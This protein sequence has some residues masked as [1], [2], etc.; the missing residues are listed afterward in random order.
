MNP[1]LIFSLMGL[2]AFLILSSC[3]D[4]APMAKADAPDP[5]Q[6]QLFNLIPASKTGLTFNNLLEENLKVNYLR[7]DG[8]YMGGGVGVGDLNNDGLDDLYF[9]GN[10]AKDQLYI[11]KGNLKFEN[12]TQTS[13]IK[14]GDTWSTGVSFVDVN[15]DGWLDIYVC[16]FLYEEAARRKN[17]LYINNG[18]LTFT[19][20]AEKY[21]IADTGY[22]IQ[23]NFFDYDKD[24]FLD[25]YIANQ[26]P[27][28]V[29]LK[30][31][32]TG[33]KDF[34]YTDR[35]Y[36]NN[37]NGSFTDVTEKAGITNYSFS[38]SCTVSDLNQDGWPDI[39]VA[40]DYEEPDF[41]YENNGDGTYRNVA[42]DAIRHMSN[43]SMGA[44]IA[45]INND[46]WFDIYTAD[47]VAADNFRLKTNMS[48]MNPEKF[49]ALAD[50]GYH[51]QFMFNALQLNNGNGTF[52]E[53]A[54]MS[55]VSNTDWSWSALLA[56]LD[57]DGYKDLHVT[58]GQLRD[59]RNNDYLI[60]RKAYVAKKKAEGVKAFN[61]LDILAL[62]PSV[63]IKNYTYR[64]NGDLTF[65]NMIEKWGL[66]QATFSQGSAYADLDNDGDLDLVLN[67]TN[68]MAGLYEN[69]TADQQLNNHLRLKLTGDQKN[70]RAIGAKVSIKY[71]DQIQIQEVSPVRGYMSASEMSLHFGLGKTQS[72]DELT[73]DWPDGRQ[74]FLEKVKVNQSLSLQHKDA[75]AKSNSASKQAIFAESTKASKVQYNHQ[76]N[77]YNDFKREILL[78][79]KMSHLGPCLATGDING[80][81]LQDFYI[82]GASQ[83]SGAL[84]L[85]STG[86][87]FT[88]STSNPW[89]KH[90]DRE[91]TGALFFDADGDQDLDLYVVSGGNEFNDQA[92]QYRDRLYLNDGKGNFSHDN[93][94][95][96][97]VSGSIATAA[98][99]DGDGD[100]DL[101]VG[102]RQVPGRYGVG[103]Q[104]YLLEN[105]NGK[106][107]DKTSDW[108][109]ELGSSGM[110]T[111]AIWTDL[112]GDK[113]VDLMLVG[114]WMPLT[115][116][117]NDGGRL[118]DATSEAG[119]DNTEG[120]WNSIN[121]ADM[122]GDGDRDLIAGNLGLNIKYKASV[123]QPFTLHVKD[124]DENGT[125]DV[126]LGYYDN[127]GVCYPVR[128]RECSSQQLPYIKKEFASYNAF[129]KASLDK[130]LGERKEGAI[131]KSAKMFE[132]VYI[133]NLGDGT[134]NI[135]TLPN[136]AQIAPTYGIVV[137]DWNK[138]GHQDLLLA[139]NYYQREVET[140][141][142]D[143][144]IGQILLGDGKG[145]F[146]AMPTAKTGLKL[147][148]DV[149]DVRMILDDR[150]NA[151]L[152][153][154]NNDAALEV[155]RSNGQLVQ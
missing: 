20:S 120:W 62:A 81:G 97:G 143:A 44:D 113:D 139:G 45:D 38:L 41:Y 153:V 127:D 135:H 16:R 30:K 131:S 70:L 128:G 39:Y 47:M 21:G 134:F 31:Q 18:D 26:P 112:D 43:F 76:E 40:C 60:E 141:R 94:N 118:V 109:P 10:L 50:A 78:P 95:L 96:P 148:K 138:D 48:G 86:G 64:N 80:D 145:Q 1:R 13:G 79:Y 77:E 84:Y 32:L 14:Q 136:Q 119:F 92:P 100:Q 126:Y 24:G 5:S 142:S 53:I 121:F 125:H 133:E 27:T 137:S 105:Q 89:L 85:Q 123:D 122:D 61:P 15:N 111:D 63:K 150:K 149:R 3:Q 104:S 102:G 19:E 88:A 154:A 147:Y 25:L 99:V 42:H 12:I 28:S 11:N 33:K 4:Q 73:I 69:S 72:V 140:T 37:G 51:Y 132:T 59:V 56:D 103:T 155:Y 17:L 9:A 107:V 74:T 55:G 82:G 57:N 152:L 7:Y 117:R 75:Q 144:G 93:Q 34:T 110:V 68:E 67:N 36:K 2:L 98:D 35:L 91:D 90:Q 46:G 52:S 22:S 114:E 29:A 83:Q 8:V 54:Q 130:V 129:A 106:F 146:E 65:T 6:V 108:A 115:Y 151:V 23:A 71:G 49:W 66:N 87:Q 124:F 58:N 116:F 101:F